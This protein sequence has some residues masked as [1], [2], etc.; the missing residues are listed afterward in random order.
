MGSPTSRAPWAHPYAWTDFALWG[1]SY[2]LSPPCP[3]GGHCC[4]TPRLSS[5]IYNPIT[6]PECKGTPFPAPR[7]APTQR[8]SPIT[9]S[10]HPQP[11]ILGPRQ[12]PSIFHGSKVKL[13]ISCLQ[14]Q[15]VVTITL[16]RAPTLCVP[17]PSSLSLLP[18]VLMGL[19]LYA[20]GWG[21]E[22]F[23]RAGFVE[24]SQWSVT[25]K[26]ISAIM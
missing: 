17:S 14:L 2:P 3:A 18:L 26:Q 20:K 4:F 19:L 23:S 22:G 25:C 6:S 1:V 9:P 21:E 8:G 11:L 24:C 15:S 7:D 5:R 10:L 16:C 13:L 12:E